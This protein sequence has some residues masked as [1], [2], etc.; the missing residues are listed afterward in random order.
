MIEIEEK[1]IGK[2]TPFLFKDESEFGKKFRKGPTYFCKVKKE[3]GWDE[4]KYFI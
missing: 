1:D 4:V 3:K 2:Y